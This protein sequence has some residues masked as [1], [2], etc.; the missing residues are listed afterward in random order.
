MPVDRA[1]VPRNFGFDP[2][3]MAAAMSC[4]GGAIAC[5]API[6]AD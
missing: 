6:A 3:D 4:A 1:R 5:W 2:T